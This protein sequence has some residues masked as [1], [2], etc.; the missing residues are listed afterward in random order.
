LLKGASGP[1]AESEIVAT[2]NVGQMRL[3]NMLK[4]LEVEGEIERAGSTWRRTSEPERSA[5]AS[6]AGASRTTLPRSAKDR[7]AWPQM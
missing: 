7:S 1:V 2:V 4:I 5:Q 3:R 6:L